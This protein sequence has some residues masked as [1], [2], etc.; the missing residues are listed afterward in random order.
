MNILLLLFM[1]SI[2][3]IL[4]GNPHELILD[5][6]DSAIKTCAGCHSSE[7]TDSRFIYNATEYNSSKDFLIN[8]TDVLPISSNIS[9]TACLCCHDGTTGSSMNFT[10]PENK[11]SIYLHMSPSLQKG[12]PVE[13]EYREGVSGLKNKNTKIFEWSYASKI[14]NLLVNGKVGCASCHNPHDKRWPR[15]LR[16]TNAGSELCFAC[17]DK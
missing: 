15:Y 17:H 14:D 5:Y 13:I 3:N 6:K 16:H 2:F 10:T 12:H 8:T 7:N 9:S 11:N 4:L 1:A